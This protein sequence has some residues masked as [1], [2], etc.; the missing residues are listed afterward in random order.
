MAKQKEIE[1]I[2]VPLDGK[3]DKWKEINELTAKGQAKFSYYAIDGNIGYHYF[4]IKK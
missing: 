3:S 4:D 2:R 1:I